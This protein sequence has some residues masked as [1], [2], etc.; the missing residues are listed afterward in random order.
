L[1]ARIEG[2]FPSVDR[3]AGDREALALALGFS[4]LGW[5]GLATSLWLSLFSLGITTAFAAVLVVIPIG[6]IAGITPLPG[7]LGGV[8]FVLVTLLVAT[9]G[10]DLA[11]A[12]AAVTIHRAATYMLPTV[13]GGG[14]AAALGVTPSNSKA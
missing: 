6:A 14:T 7:G 1:E 8:E 12:T 5:I 11:T 13:V 9:T 2:F 10:V 3:V 4:F